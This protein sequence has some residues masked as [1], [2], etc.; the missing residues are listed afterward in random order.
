MRQLLECGSSLPLSERGIA[1][2][3]R[4]RTA[5]LQDAGAFIAAQIEMKR[6]EDQEETVER[7]TSYL[8]KLVAKRDAA[9][10]RPARCASGSCWKAIGN[11]R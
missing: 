1:T 7:F 8:E 3:K 4:Q 5:A 9:E 10:M 11:R 2:P 6:L